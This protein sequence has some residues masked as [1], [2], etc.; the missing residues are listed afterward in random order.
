MTAGQRFALLI[1]G[2]GLVF[3]ML[4]AVAGLLWRVA[5][6]ASRTLTEVK[7]HAEDI[8]EIASSLDRHL[9]WHIDHPPRR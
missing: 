8:K 4:T 2:L 9:R 5:A 6:S 1:S 7:A 3:G